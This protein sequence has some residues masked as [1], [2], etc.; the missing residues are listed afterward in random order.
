MLQ[1]SASPG[2]RRR[3]AVVSPKLGPHIAWIDAVL[4]ADRGV[5]AKQR[6]T[7]PRLFDRL[8]TEEGY[9]GGYTVVREYV[10]SATLCSREMFVPLSHRPR[11]AQADFGETDAYIA[12]QKVRFH[13][14]CMDLPQ[15]SERIPSNLMGAMGRAGYPDSQPDSGIHGEQGPDHPLRRGVLPAT[16]FPAS[17]IRRMTHMLRS[18]P[19]SHPGTRMA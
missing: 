10:A 4:E 12:G 17:R 6:H 3:E 16:A 5:H 8:R 7:A 19:Y 14:F 13:Y 11:H 1:Y 2:Y 9:S 18:F 15:S